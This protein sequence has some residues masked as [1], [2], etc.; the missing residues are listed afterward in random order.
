MPAGDL[1]EGLTCVWAI[2][3]SR[4]WEGPKSGTGGRWG[5]SSAGLHS[6]CTAELDP[7]GRRD[8]LKAAV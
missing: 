2:W 8:G 3:R 4:G 6:D 5:P 1:G 7:R